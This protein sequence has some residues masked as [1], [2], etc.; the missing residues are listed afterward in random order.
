MQANKLEDSIESLHQKVIKIIDFLKDNQINLAI[1]LLKLT[2]KDATHLKLWGV[3]CF[4]E[5]IISFTNNKQLL[6]SL[7]NFSHETCYSKHLLQHSID[8]LLDYIKNIKLGLYDIPIFYLTY[9]DLLKI[10]TNGFILSLYTQS[11]FFVKHV[12]KYNTSSFRC[13]FNATQRINVINSIE[14]LANFIDFDF[15]VSEFDYTKATKSVLVLK[16]EFNETR[17]ELLWN[18]CYIIFKFLENNI[19]KHSDKLIFKYLFNNIIKNYSD[20]LDNMSFH[21]IEDKVNKS[22]ASLSYILYQYLDNEFLDEKFQKQI[23]T[24]QK[25]PK[26][27]NRSSLVEFRNNIDFKDISVIALDFYSEL[28]FATNNFID[29]KKKKRMGLTEI[30]KI[31]QRQKDS[32]I[33]IGYYEYWFAYK[34]IFKKINNLL[35]NKFYLSS[36]SISKAQDDLLDLLDHLSK[37]QGSINNADNLPFCLDFDDKINHHSKES[38]EII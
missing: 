30:L 27:N 14:F 28:D 1:D 32:F 5:E 24:L 36:K 13:D 35:K 11:S 2:N 37:L 4:T 8:A 33:I 26:K 22:L 18:F 38:K 31:L 25:L 29:S 3:V 15:T 23:Y 10:N 20:G 6:Q 34:K 21:L 16:N 12:E 9:L 7:L 17:H 19:L